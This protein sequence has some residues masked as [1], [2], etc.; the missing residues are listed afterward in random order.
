MTVLTPALRAHFRLLEKIPA[1]KIHTHRWEPLAR[2]WGYKRN[3]A[4]EKKIAIKMR[5]LE[6][7]GYTRTEI[8]DMLHC[9]TA[10]IVK[11]LG[12]KRVV[13]RWR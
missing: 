3:S 7:C 12:R 13:T 4:E 1:D 5:A 8:M 9:S 11:Y 10:T 6:Q 2:E